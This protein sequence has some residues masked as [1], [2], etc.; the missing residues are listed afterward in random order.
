MRRLFSKQA[1]AGAV[2]KAIM[3]GFMRIVPSTRGTF[4]RDVLDGVTDF[5]AMFLLC[6]LCEATLRLVRGQ[7]PHLEK[8]R[9]FC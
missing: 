7:Q 5:L 4:R 1:K 9:F 8:I 6:L 2:F 3:S